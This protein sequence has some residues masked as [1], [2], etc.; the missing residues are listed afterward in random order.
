MK[1]T[2]TLLAIGTAALLAGPALAQSSA[3]DNPQLNVRESQNYNSM[4]DHSNSF[5]AERMR[6]ECDPIQSDDLRRQCIESFG[7]TSSSGAGDQSTRSTRS[8]V[9]R[10]TR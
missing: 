9:G 10:G 4:V 3:A 2:T 7:A 6:K 8:G 5:R 1:F